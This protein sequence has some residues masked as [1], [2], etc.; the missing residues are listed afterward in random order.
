MEIEKALTL[1]V[2]DFV[3]YPKDRGEPGGM[4]EITSVSEN[5][6]IYKNIYGI[7]YIWVNLKIGGVWPTNRLS[8]A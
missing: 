3:W 4:S 5:P 1:K 8:K 6:T 2:G 7:E